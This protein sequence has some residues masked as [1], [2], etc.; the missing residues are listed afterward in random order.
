MGKRAKIIVEIERAIAKLEDR[1]GLCLYYAHH[2]AR[3]LYQH[4]YKAVIQA[5][6]LQWPRLAEMTVATLTSPICGRPMILQARC[7]R[8]WA[9]CPKCTSGQGS[10]TSKSWWTSRPDIWS[11]PHWH[12]KC[13]GRPPHRLGISGA[14]H[15]N[16]RRELSIGPIET[17]RSWPA[18]FSKSSSI[19]PTWLGSHLAGL[20][21]RKKVGDLICHS[22]LPRP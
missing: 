8:G 6:S 12:S 4:G 10:W 9:A 21:R 15:R 14:Q 13:S 11:R 2:T 17:P 22:R 1:P 7:R 3:I 18:R 19:Q 16:S 20:Q 5:G